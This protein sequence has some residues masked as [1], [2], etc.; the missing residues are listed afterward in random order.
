MKKS[1]QTELPFP[2]K[3]EPFI[4]D[5]SYMFSVKF[6]AIA[7]ITTEQLKP[8][9]FIGKGRFCWVQHIEKIE[10]MEDRDAL[11][12]TYDGYSIKSIS[13]PGEEYTL[14]ELVNISTLDYLKTMQRY[15]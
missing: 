12:V 6:R 11:L 1:N 9:M 14:F 15:G 5:Q 13:T 7:N 8:G 10:K 3:F 4:K 2:V